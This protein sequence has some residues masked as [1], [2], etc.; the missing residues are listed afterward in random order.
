MI[1]G[2]LIA[3]TS[4]V[5][6]LKQLPTSLVMTHGYVNP[7]VAVILDWL[8]LSE[9]LTVSTIFGMLMILIGVGMVFRDRTV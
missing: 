7:V 4:Y 8:I 5:A 2:S 6:A 3:F 9:P 1:F